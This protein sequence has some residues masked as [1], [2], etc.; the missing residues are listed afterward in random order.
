MAGKS[1]RIKRN[2]KKILAFGFLRKMSGFFFS[3]TLRT[4][5]EKK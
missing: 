1:K 5:E 4:D 3:V 2:I